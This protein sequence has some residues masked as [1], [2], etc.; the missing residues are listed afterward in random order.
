MRACIF[1]VKTK[2]ALDASINVTKLLHVTR[3]ACQKKSLLLTT[4]F[5]IN[6]VKLLIKL[7]RKTRVKQ[8]GMCRLL[9]L[10]KETKLPKLVESFV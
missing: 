6:D 9:K 7:R 3:H 5:L 4:S 2:S 8:D 10:Y 1:M